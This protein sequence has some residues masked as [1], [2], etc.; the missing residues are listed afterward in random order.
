VNTIRVEEPILHSFGFT[1]LDLRQFCGVRFIR[2]FDLD[3]TLANFGFVSVLAEDTLHKAGDIAC[4]GAILT[5]FSG[6]D[7]PTL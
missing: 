3:R 2:S 4:H 5:G 7:L 6:D 1:K